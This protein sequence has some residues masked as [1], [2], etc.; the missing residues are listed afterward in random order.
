MVILE[1]TPGAGSTVLR[2]DGYKDVFS[3]EPS[4]KILASQPGNYQRV[5]GN[6]VAE[7]L[8]TRFPQTKVILAAN[9]EMALGAIQAVEAR[10]LKLGSD[11][12]V[13]G[14]NAQTEAVKAVKDGKLLASV[15]ANEVGMAYTAVKV[16][17]DYLKNGTKPAA[18]LIGQNGLV[19][20]KSNADSF[21]RQQ[22]FK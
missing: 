16:T 12:Y 1:G 22:E 21:N 3:K 19:V 11:I 18:T 6:Q 2:N 5:K 17:V 7:D 15:Y 13:V 14:F 20:D 9:D 8:L 10:G 4:I